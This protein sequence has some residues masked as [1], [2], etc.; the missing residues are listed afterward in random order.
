M[1]SKTIDEYEFGPTLGRGSFGEVKVAI[2]IHTEREVAIKIIDKSVGKSEEELNQL[3][4]EIRILSLLNHKNVVRLYDVIET[5][6]NTYIV[7]EFIEGQELFDYLIARRRLPEDEARTLFQQIVDGV[8]HCHSRKIAHRDL[9][10]ENMLLDRRGMVKIIDF[11]LA[12]EI[13]P[14]E[15]LT[16][17][18]GTLN[19]AAPEIFSATEHNGYEGP[20]VDVW[21]CGVILFALLCGRLPFVGECQPELESAILKGQLTLPKFL[22]SDAKDLLTKMLTKDQGERITIAE[23][24]QH[25]WFLA[26]DQENLDPSLSTRSTTADSQVS[27]SPSSTSPVARDLLTTSFVKFELGRSAKSKRDGWLT[28]AAS[29]HSWRGSEG[30]GSRKRDGWLTSAASVHSWRGSEGSGSRRLRHR[31]ARPCV[32][33]PAP[34]SGSPV[35]QSPRDE[36][37]SAKLET[38]TFKNPPP[39]CQWSQLADLF[40]TDFVLHELGKPPKDTLGSWVQDPAAPSRQGEVSRTRRVRFR[41]SRQSGD[42]ST[43]IS[44][45]VAD[46]LP[47]SEAKANW[48]AESQTAAISECT[49][50]APF[51]VTLSS[52]FPANLLTTDFVV[53]ELGRPPKEDKSGGWVRGTTGVT[54]R[55]S[56]CSTKGMIFR[57]PR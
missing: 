11:G 24:R 50:T 51:A 2:N 34:A 35:Q 49:T 18:C 13:T 23:I 37:P 38:R 44:P 32:A 26:A 3:Q 42:E 14:G 54:H 17:S 47:K 41:A 5:D 10:L 25:A 33:S 40:S 15:R 43:S 53:C 52:A 31:A 6:S 56:N 4:E 36:L 39:P 29:V 21:S 20:E 48:A 55:P 19:Y 22:S 8:D 9:K 45:L 57:A 28:S 30:S 27:T 46:K 12:A 7:M 1:P 16:K